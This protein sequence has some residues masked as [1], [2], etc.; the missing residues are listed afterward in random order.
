MSDLD[1]ATSNLSL[2]EEDE[3]C[4]WYRRPGFGEHA[5]PHLQAGRAALATVLC[6]E[7][8]SLTQE[9][10]GVRP[11]S[12]TSHSEQ[13]DIG[14]SSVTRVLPGPEY[15]FRKPYSQ[16]RGDANFCALCRAVQ[17][18]VVIT[19]RYAAGHHPTPIPLDSHVCLQPVDDGGELMGFLVRVAEDEGT[20]ETDSETSS[21]T[22]SS[23]SSSDTSSG[24]F[25]SNPTWKGF[26]E[27]QVRETGTHILNRT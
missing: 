6:G 27:V 21:E 4:E 14:G 19:Q 18:S 24:G 16:L 12:S 26:L 17:D 15:T 8:M 20:S 1:Q 11:K 3:L 10:L 7:C 9:M 22:S 5:S 23:T 13:G 25:K 2:G